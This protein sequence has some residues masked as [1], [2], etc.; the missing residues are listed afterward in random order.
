MGRPS[1]HVSHDIA[2]EKR[3]RPPENVLMASRSTARAR[4]VAALILLVA[5]APQ[6]PAV[7]EV[8]ESVLREYAG[9]YQWQPNA[10]AYLQLWD[11]YSGFGKPR[12]LV[13]FDESGDVR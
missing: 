8:D 3:A 7:R 10:F 11:E 4:L 13:A 5:A 12:Q 2:V 1:R 6:P 9:V